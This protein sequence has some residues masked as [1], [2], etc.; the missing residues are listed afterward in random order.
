MINLKLN[1]WWLFNEHLEHATEEVGGIIWEHPEAGMSQ[2]LS[3][4]LILS[5]EAERTN[6]F[7]LYWSR[8]FSVLLGKRRKEAWPN[9]SLILRGLMTDNSANMNHS[10]S[11]RT[12]SCSY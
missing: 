7:E 8:E 5:C 11:I 3:I 1:N 6:E 9:E 10:L 4:F 2:V 12:E